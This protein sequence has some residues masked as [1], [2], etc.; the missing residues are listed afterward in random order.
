MKRKNNFYIYKENDLKD[1]KTNHH[2]HIDK[3]VLKKEQKVTLKKCGI[4]K[5]DTNDIYNNSCKCDI[6]FHVSLS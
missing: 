3:Q 1:I 2:N 4:S 5:I 6:V